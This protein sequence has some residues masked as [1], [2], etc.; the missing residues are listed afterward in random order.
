M[1]Y[2]L[3][4]YLMVALILGVFSSFVVKK[5]LFTKDLKPVAIQKG[6]MAHVLVAKTDLIAGCEFTSQ[7]IRFDLIPESMIPRDAIFST[8][9]VLQRKA[10][11]D[12]PKDAVITLFDIQMQKNEE[13][14]K[15][16]SFIPP[17]YSVVPIQIDSISNVENGGDLSSYLKLDEILKVGDKVELSVIHREQINSKDASKR[18]TIPK[19][20]VQTIVPSA[21]IYKI[22]TEMRVSENSSISHRFSVLSL[23]LDEEG[24][25]RLKKAGSTGRIRLSVLQKEK[26]FSDGK[27]KQDFL[28][29]STPL[30]VGKPVENTDHFVVPQN[31]LK[32]SENQSGSNSNSSSLGN[33]HFTIQIDAF[34]R[35]PSEKRNT[36]ASSEKPAPKEIVSTKMDPNTKKELKKEDLIKKEPKKSMLILSE[37][38]GSNDP[39]SDQK[40][41]NKKPSTFNSIKDQGDRSMIDPQLLM[42]DKREPSFAGNDQPGIA[43]SSDFIG[44]KDLNEIPI[45]QQRSHPSKEVASAESSPSTLFRYRPG[46]S[47]SQTTRSMDFQTSSL[48]HQK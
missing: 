37:Q 34:K 22:F 1:Q 39:A 13:E 33:N 27:I 10:S 46:Y 6:P 21:D 28:L 17:G 20:V 5:A 35:K 19:L 42:T 31:S 8:E 14:E 41:E 12:I 2:K 11:V 9:G 45:S 40:K 32:G 43:Y 15:T 7:N 48:T 26:N 18:G 16:V 25:K 24:I 36:T 29:Q 47:T 30:P 38:D 44:E 4:I 23:L 3:L